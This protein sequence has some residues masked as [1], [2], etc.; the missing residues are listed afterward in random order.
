MGQLEKTEAFSGKWWILAGLWLLYASFGLVVASVAP[1]VQDI[2]NELSMSH[3]AMGSVM[4]AW[5]LVYIFAAIPCGILLDRIGGRYALLMAAALIGASALG[6]AFA[7]DYWCFLIAVMLFGIGGPIVSSG[8]PKVVAEYFTGSQRGLA[9]GIYMTGP[10]IGGVVCLTMTNAFFLPL[11]DMNWRYVMAM[12]GVMAL[13]AGVIWWLLASFLQVDKR[14]AANRTES[15]PQL[16]I[17]AE[18]IKAPAVRVLLLM[19]VGVFLYNHG[20]NNWL[21]ELLRQGGK[22]AVQA[23]YWAALPTLVGILGSLLIPRLATPARRFHILIFL[24]VAALLASVLLQALDNVTLTTG[25]ILQ[26]VARS[27]LMTVLILTLVELPGIGEQRVGVASGMFFSAAEVGGMLGPFGMG[28]IYDVTGGF[29]ASLWSLSI[30]SV[31]MIGGALYLRRLAGQAQIPT[32][33]V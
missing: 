24:C 30:V 4:G 29:S 23:G 32:P 15:T 1:M 26:G 8:A 18:L 28:V 25:L 22:S 7:T 16:Q 14:S 11:F 20:L 33:A 9:M 6:R 12:W 21:P 19:S 5:Q 13:V 10:A 27:S 2:L 3:S 17:M 31:A